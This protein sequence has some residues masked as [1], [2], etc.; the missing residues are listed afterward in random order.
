MADIE[1]VIKLPEEI[2]KASQI[3]VV[4]S[5]ILDDLR[6]EIETIDAALIKE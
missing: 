2:C 1:L 5:G 4:I 6:A 3:M